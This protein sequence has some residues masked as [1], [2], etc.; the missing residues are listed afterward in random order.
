MNLKTLQIVRN[1][2]L[3]KK[4]VSETNIEKFLMD[5]KLESKKRAKKIMKE[6]DSLKDSTLMISFWEEFIESNIIIPEE[7][8]NKKEKIN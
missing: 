6:L 3:Q 7:V 4:L 2:L 8:D 5:E 1:E